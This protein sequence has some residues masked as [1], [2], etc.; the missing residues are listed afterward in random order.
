MIP[1]ELFPFDYV[2]G[3]YFKK[4]NVPKGK[5]AEILHGMQAIEYI[6]TEVQ[7][8]EKK[9]KDTMIEGIVA[10]RMSIIKLNSALKSTNNVIGES[11]ED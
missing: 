2:G 8:L 6:Y 4:K 7:H 5:R 3:G 9:A 11:Y 1:K 10:T